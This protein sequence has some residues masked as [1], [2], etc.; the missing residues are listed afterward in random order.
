VFLLPSDISVA[1]SVLLFPNDWTRSLHNALHSSLVKT[2]AT[3]VLLSDPPTKSKLTYLF[4]HTT[5]L[6]PNTIPPYSLSPKLLTTHAVY[7]KVLPCKTVCRHTCLPYI[8]NSS[9]LK[10]T[11]FQPPSELPCMLTISLPGKLMVYIAERI[12]ND[13]T[14]TWW[15]YLINL[16]VVIMHTSM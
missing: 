16:D 4:T 8:Y 7:H 1:K 15:V 11:C 6:S 12:L 9:L 13:E 2:V 14:Q 5:T 10:M 3:Y